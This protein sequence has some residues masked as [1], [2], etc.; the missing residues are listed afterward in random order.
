MTK[1]V[2]KQWGVYPGTFARRAEQ[3][4][5]SQ[6]IGI[7]EVRSEILQD[8]NGSTLKI[9]ILS[10]HVITLK[11]SYPVKTFELE[12]G[13]L[14]N[15]CPRET[16]YYGVEFLLNELF[17]PNLIILTNINLRKYSKKN[18]LPSSYKKWKL[19]WRLWNLSQSEL[20]VY[21]SSCT[22]DLWKSGLEQQ[23]QLKWQLALTAVNG[24]SPFLSLFC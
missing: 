13:S 16:S 11:P 22:A 3:Q 6:D 1:S 2:W 15:L 5:N 14:R 7:C 12:N 8:I 21:I 19:F 4:I 24:F 23:T 10:K 18:L 17:D 20:S 9:S